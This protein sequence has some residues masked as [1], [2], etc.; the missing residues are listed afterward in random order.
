MGR[1][2]QKWQRPRRALRISDGNSS[3]AMNVGS[4]DVISVA[5]GRLVC[6]WRP[7][8]ARDFLARLPAPANGR[9]SHCDLARRVRSLAIHLSGGR[10]PAISIQTYS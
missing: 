8:A 5:I 3:R 10:E 7:A 9:K 2:I 6:R 4:R 1:E